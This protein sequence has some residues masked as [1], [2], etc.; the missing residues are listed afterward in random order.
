VPDAAALAAKDAGIAETYKAEFARKA[1]ADR[2]KLAEKLIREADGATTDPPFRFALLR[3]AAGLAADAGDPALALKA[4]DAL[5]ETFA[6]DAAAER[7]A[8]L[9]RTAATGQTAAVR[10]AAEAALDQADALADRDEYD[11]AVRLAGLAAGWLAKAGPPAAHRDAEARQAEVARQRELFAPVRAAAERLKADPADPAASLAVG[12][13][14][15]FVQGR[16]ADGAPLVAAGPDPALKKLGE[17]EAKAGT[18]PE[19][20]D[21]GRGDAWAE[22]A[23]RGPE[24]DRPAARG[25]SRYWYGRALAQPAERDRA[26]DKLA[27]TE[28]KV[29]YRPGVLLEAYSLQ[30][31]RPRLGRIDPVVA[32]EAKDF[33]PATG[34]A[35]RLVWTGRLVAPA[36]GRYRLIADTA[37]P[38]KLT[39]LPPGEDRVLFDVKSG[40]RKPA[41][42]E[43]VLKADRPQAFTLEYF[44]PTAGQPPHA[45]SL[46]WV[47]PGQKNAEPVPPSALYWAGTDKA[48][49]TDRSGG[50]T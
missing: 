14:R 37:D 20:T 6:V 19:T 38:V 4:A 17:L 50:G 35:V 31:K 42:G 44:A 5:A 3:Q 23:E 16:W 47:R 13:H 9:E 43:V 15:W 24:A 2:R 41:E 26:A 1:P 21:A 39:L 28:G 18:D 10:A 32:A 36:G 49:V 30:V 48:K 11:A 8:A 46:R 45:V 12:R 33:R 25:R 40:Q 22:Y 27:F 7:A 34:T 29:E